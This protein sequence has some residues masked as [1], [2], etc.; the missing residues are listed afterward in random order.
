[1]HEKKLEERH[2]GVGIHREKRRQKLLEETSD[3]ESL[4]SEDECT[5]MAED[6]FSK[7]SSGVKLPVTGS[8]D[9]FR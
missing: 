1:M 7:T 3:S 6:L 4:S 5:S 8:F 2:A 9:T